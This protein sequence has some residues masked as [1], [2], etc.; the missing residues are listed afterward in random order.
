MKTGRWQLSTELEVENI[1]DD[2]NAYSDDRLPDWKKSVN[3]L[4]LF[5]QVF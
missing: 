2:S 5:S 3:A 4:V 1:R